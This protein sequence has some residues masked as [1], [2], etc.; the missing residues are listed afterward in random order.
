MK[1][2]SLQIWDEASMSHKAS[3]E[4]LDRAMQDLCNSNCPVGGCTILFSGDFCQILPVITTGTGADEVN[5]SL[6][7][8]YLWPHIMKCKLKTNIRIVSSS[9]DNRQFSTDAPNW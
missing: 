3:V 8:L 1:D 7:R 6:K 5:T 4:A 9:K 2:C